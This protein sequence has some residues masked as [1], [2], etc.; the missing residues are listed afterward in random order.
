M[1]CAKTIQCVQKAWCLA[2]G[3]ASTLI[4]TKNIAV[5][6]RHVRITKFVAKG[7]SVAKAYAKRSNR[8]SQAMSSA[9]TRIRASILRSTMP[10]AV[11]TLFV[12]LSPLAKPANDANM[13][14]AA[15]TRNAAKWLRR[16][17]A[18][19]RRPSSA[20]SGNSAT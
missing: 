4:E 1:A 10:T 12:N 18:A 19:R 9:P 14:N 11:P 5:P 16:Q 13:A 8:A 6:M 17:K 20:K 15:P 2:V 3:D 7:R